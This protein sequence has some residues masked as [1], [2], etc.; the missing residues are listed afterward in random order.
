MQILRNK[1]NILYKEFV[2]IIYI[3]LIKTSKQDT[4]TIINKTYLAIKRSILM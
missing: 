3:L 1:I 4:I 2:Y